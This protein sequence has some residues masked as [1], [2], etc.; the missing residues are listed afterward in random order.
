MIELECVH[1]EH[2]NLWQVRIITGWR[3]AHVMIMDTWCEHQW[4][5]ENLADQTYQKYI[6]G[7]LF[8]HKSDALMFMLTWNHT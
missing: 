5:P 4:G 1:D 3:L 6:K 7:W 8:K 2:K